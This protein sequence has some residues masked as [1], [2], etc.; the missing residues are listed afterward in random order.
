MQIKRID[1]A[2]DKEESYVWVELTSKAKT[3]KLMPDTWEEAGWDCEDW[4]ANNAEDLN[5]YAFCDVGHYPKI[6]ILNSQLQLSHGE[7][8]SLEEE[9]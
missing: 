8:D 7:W 1:Y 5:H 2:T 6:D 4:I 9:E 3:C